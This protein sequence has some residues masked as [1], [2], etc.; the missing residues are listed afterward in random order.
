MPPVGFAFETIRKFLELKANRD[1]FHSFQSLDDCRNRLHRVGSAWL[2]FGTAARYARRGRDSNSA[3]TFYRSALRS[4]PKNNELL[5]RAFISSLADGDI[6][7]AVK[8][9]DRILTIDKSN[10]VARLVVGV[11]DLKLKKYAAAQLN[12]NQSIRG[13]ITDLVATLLSG[14]AGYGA[15]DSKTAIANIDKLTGP[16]WYPLFKDLH[17][18]MILELAGKEKDAGLRLERAHKLDD[19]MLRVADANPRWLSRNKDGAGATAVS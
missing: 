17:A 12:I 19:S 11:R 9:A 18:G 15:G 8:L 5:D 13:P 2:A 6:D 14:W 4:D 3:A 16:E 1:D 7:E 10:R